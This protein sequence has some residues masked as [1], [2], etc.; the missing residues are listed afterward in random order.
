MVNV[1]CE[2]IGW[3]SIHNVCSALFTWRSTL[4]AARDWTDC[5]WSPQVV[6]CTG[7]GGS[8]VLSPSA[9]QSAPQLAGRKEGNPVSRRG[10]AETSVTTSGD[11]HAR[12]AS[13]MWENISNISIF[14][15]RA[16]NPQYRPGVVVEL[17]VCGYYIILHC[18]I[19]NK[20]LGINFFNK[21]RIHLLCL[22]LC[23]E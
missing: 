5:A 11:C 16:N 15:S 18:Q 12:T 7:G 21:E 6:V 4:C 8:G 17:K 2:R 3:C 1:R 14:S 19:N 10:G 20:A 9:P 22:L 23:T 13:R